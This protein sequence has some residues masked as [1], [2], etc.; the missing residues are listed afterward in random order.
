MTDEFT[1]EVTI[2]NIILSNPTPAMIKYEQHRQLMLDCED[3]AAWH[4]EDDRLRA[5]MLKEAAEQEARGEPPCIRVIME[6]SASEL[7]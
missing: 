7:E 4:L 6:W 1:N 5:E 3:L 2:G